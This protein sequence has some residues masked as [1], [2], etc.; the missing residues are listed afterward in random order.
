MT[1]LSELLQRLKFCILILLFYSATALAKTET[2][3]FQIEY[4]AENNYLSAGTATWSL[5]KKNSDWVMQLSTSPSRL[6]RL[7]GV[8]KV[9]ETSV[10]NDLEPPFQ[11]SSYRYTDSKRKRKNYAATISATGNE[12]EIVRPDQTLSIPVNGIV[13]ID[14]L[15]ATLAVARHLES[16]P[17]FK[18]LEFKVLDRNG[19]R[20][21]V[22]TNLGTETLTLGK[23]SFSAFIVEN[24]RP[25]STRKTRTWFGKI[26]EDSKQRLLPI[27]IEQYKGKELVLRLSLK[28]YTLH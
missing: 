1:R 13:V 24:S 9:V 2:G 19:V 22:C 15:A 20:D 21:M 11:A 4:T 26:D 28:H 3:S 5:Q 23:A 27:K 14:R 6:V 7:A 17:K 18:S 8:G 12:I 10:L 16:D 25:G